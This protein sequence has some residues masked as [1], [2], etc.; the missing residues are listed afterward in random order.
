MLSLFNYCYRFLSVVLPTLI[1]FSLLR[2]YYVRRGCHVPGKTLGYIMVFAVYIAAVFY[3]TGAGTL[4]DIIVNIVNNIR[5]SS[6][7][8]IDLQ[9]LSPKDRLNDIL[10][11][12][13]CVPLGLLLPAVWPRARSLF[14]TAL[15]GLLF[16]L[17]I[18]LSQLL[19]FRATDIDDLI[20]NTLGAVIGYFG[21]KLCAALREKSGEQRVA[22]REQALAGENWIFMSA[23]FFGHFAL[24]DIAKFVSPLFRG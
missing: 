22:Y 21:Y 8:R 13:M 9:V 11:I 15:T 17:L 2:R 3:F 10:N 19:N 7:F 14:V 16:S 1:V 4:A 18:E 5:I 23:M 12:V 20:M 6:L 24:F